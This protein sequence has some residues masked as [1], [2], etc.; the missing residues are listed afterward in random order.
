[1]Q[2]QHDEAP[3]L[4]VLWVSR[5]PEAARNMALMYAKNSRLKGWWDTVHLLVWGPSAEL[6]A[7]D[8]SLQEEVADCMAA[9]VT[10]LACRACADRYG[11][12]EALEALG[13]TV[14]YTGEPMTAYLKG[15]W[16]VLSV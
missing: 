16:K 13:V 14:Q 2:P 11:V 15:G 1:M 4:V 7:G 6:L 8:A 10:V 3:G 12:A 9:G 5:D